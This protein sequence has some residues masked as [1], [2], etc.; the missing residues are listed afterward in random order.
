MEL[1]LPSRE[2]KNK[3]IHTQDTAIAECPAE[4]HFMKD[5]FQGIK[6]PNVMI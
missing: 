3:F 2:F 4:T 6:I 5:A 1:S